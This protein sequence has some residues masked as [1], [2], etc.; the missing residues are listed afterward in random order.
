MIV[1]SFTYGKFNEVDA[2]EIPSE[3]RN[4]SG[5]G[6]QTNVWETMKLNVGSASLTI[7]ECTVQEL[8]DAGF[9]LD[10]DLPE[11]MEPGDTQYLTVL[12]GEDDFS[13]SVENM[14]SETIDATDAT[15][16]GFSGMY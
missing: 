10:S 11:T 9:T 16:Y 3:V 12:R 6:T 1:F 7:G 4:L 2:I 8:L 13:L 5:G 15:V 14:T